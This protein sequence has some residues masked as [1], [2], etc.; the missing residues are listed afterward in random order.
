MALGLHLD[1]EIPSSSNPEELLDA[2]WMKEYRKRIWVN[3][4]K[5]DR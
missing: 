5:W 4:F 3:I 2:L 1:T